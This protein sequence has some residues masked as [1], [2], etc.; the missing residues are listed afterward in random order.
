VHE[1]SIL[2]KVR[3]NVR[4]QLLYP[5]LRVSEHPKYDVALMTQQSANLA[6]LVIMIYEQWR[7]SPYSSQNLSLND[8][9]KRTSRAVSPTSHHTPLASSHSFSVLPEQTHIRDVPVDMRQSLLLPL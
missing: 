3:A 5:L 6:C 7:I 9:N 2:W 4:Q 8:R 1:P